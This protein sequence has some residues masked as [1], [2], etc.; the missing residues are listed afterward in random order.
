MIYAIVGGLSEAEI[1]I[2]GN[3]KTA[4]MTYFLFKAYLNKF[5]VLTNYHL[6]FSD[7]KGRKRTLKPPLY[8]NAEEIKDKVLN[9]DLEN[10]TI[11]IDEIQLFLNSLGE[12]K[13][14]VKSFTNELMAQT[15]KRKVDAYWTTQIYYDVQKRARAQTDMILQPVK[16][17]LN[18]DICVKDTCDKKH[19][20]E[21]WSIYP[22]KMLL[23]KIRAEVIGTFYDQN[24]IIKTIK[25]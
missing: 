23:Q 7:P 21:I 22:K 13:E 3:G 10:I 4:T 14:I 15:R 12:K 19:I 9:D 2:R 6:N 16:R 17:H 11:G 25:N 18:K 24:E 5:Q 20:I 1:G 8:L